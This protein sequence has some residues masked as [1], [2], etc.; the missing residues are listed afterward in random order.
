MSADPLFWLVAV[1]AVVIVGVSKGGFGGGLGVAGVPVMALYMDPVL[2]AAILLPVLCAMD[3]MNLWA[4]WGR[5]DVRSLLRLLPAS[6]LGIAAGWLLFG[7]L[8]RDVLR[9]L[10]G[11]IA[12]GF[13]LNVWL[14]RSNAERARPGV[15][16]AGGWGAAAG[17][18]SFVAHA[19]GPPLNM[20]LLPQRLP[21]QVY[22]ATTVAFFAV[23]NYVKLVPYAM[24]GQLNVGNLKLAVMLLPVAAA[25]IGLGVWLHR[26]VSEAQFYRIAYVLL[27]LTGL[28]LIM[29]G[30]GVE[31]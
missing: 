11:A 1:T 22:Q 13:T 17:L 6:V 5:W 27:F 12:V 18:T 15:I 3:L 10:V 23:V 19:G 31:F 16:A 21:R 4:F 2:A 29:D 30:L 8:D 26:R 28:K 9:L 24:L 20:Y 7:Y 25:G 14:R